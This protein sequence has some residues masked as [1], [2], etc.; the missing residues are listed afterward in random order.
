MIFQ[1]KYFLLTV[2]LFIVE[3]L[4]ALFVHD[5]IVRPYIG[6]VLVVILIY[7]FLKIFIK[8]HN[9]KIA[10]GVL[11]FS[12]LVELLQYLQ[13]VKILGWEKST[14]AKTI[15]G[16]SASFADLLAYTLGFILILFIDRK[17]I[18]FS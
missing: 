1:K 12:F 18:S 5:K 11:I 10:A 6:D 3:I 9:L 4:I 16:H 8:G 14:L 15:I 13:I 7:S 2:I 17:T